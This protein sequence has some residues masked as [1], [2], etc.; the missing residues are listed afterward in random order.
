MEEGFWFSS[1]LSIIVTSRICSLLHYFVLFSASCLCMR[2]LCFIF[3]CF[4][5]VAWFLVNLEQTTRPQF[6]K[7]W[8][9]FCWKLH[10]STHIA[11][12]IAN[13]STYTR[14]RCCSCQTYAICSNCFLEKLI[15][16]CFCQ[17]GNIANCLN[18]F[19][20]ILLLMVNGPISI[21]IINY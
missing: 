3:H 14:P 8:V 1:A 20:M 6:G 19:W 2:D 7:L 15:A 12:T 21:V 5:F 17:I 10:S 18:W 11:F 9:S 13:G 4:W 16:S